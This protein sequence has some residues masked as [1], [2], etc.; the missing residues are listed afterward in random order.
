MAIPILGE[1]LN[2]IQITGV[3][4]ALVAIYLFNVPTE[5]S[6][7]TPWV[8]AALLP[9]L[10]WGVAGC[11]K[12]WRPMLCQARL[13]C[14][15]FWGVCAA[16]GLVVLALRNSDIDFLAT[17][18]RDTPDGVLFGAGKSGHLVG[19]RVEGKASIFPRSA[20]VP[21]RQPPPRHDF[22]GERVTSRE[23]LAIGIALVAV[24]AM[25]FERP[26]TSANPTLS[27]TP[28]HPGAS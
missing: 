25:A 17:R 21:R 14:V 19:V 11:C 8:L 4:G 27:A 1:R 23:W 6:Y 2:A 10:L 24:M 9:I 7:L 20:H 3:L 26:A 5:Q 16:G 15:G 13:P 28:L 18:P 22:S 12:K